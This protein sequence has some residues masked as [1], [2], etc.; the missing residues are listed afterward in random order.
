MPNHASVTL[1]GHIGEPKISGEGDSMCA[2]FGLA[3]T[4]KR[5]AG[6]LTTWFNVT[7]WR[8]DAAFVAQYVKKG[9]LMLVEGEPYEDEYEG[10]KYLKVDARRVLNLS[11]RGDGEQAPAPAAKGASPPKKPAPAVGDDEPPF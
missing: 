6:D 2:R 11:P 4:R 7:C 5:K 3:I 8:K 9:Q 1:V 10:K